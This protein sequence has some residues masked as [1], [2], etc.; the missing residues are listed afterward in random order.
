LEDNLQPE[1]T[2]K[3]KVKPEDIRRLASRPQRACICGHTTGTIQGSFVR[4]KQIV[5]LYVI[6]TVGFA[7]V[8]VALLP[9]SGYSL[10]QLWHEIFSR[11]WWVILIEAVWFLIFAVISYRRN[12]AGHSLRCSI[13]YALL[14]AI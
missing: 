10:G 11:A 13:R 2:F 12:K 1:D 5:W 6:T 14:R 9:W 3:G 4:V 7:I 8:P